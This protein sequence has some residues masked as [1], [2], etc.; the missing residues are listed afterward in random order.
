MYILFQ[1]STQSPPPWGP[2]GW[3]GRKSTAVV[4]QWS[5]SVMIMRG[6]IEWW[7]SVADLNVAAASA[8]PKSFVATNNRTGSPKIAKC[9]A[10]DT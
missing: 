7:M 2:G 9:T 8:A 3:R 4:A 10:D 1:H 6:G 5:S